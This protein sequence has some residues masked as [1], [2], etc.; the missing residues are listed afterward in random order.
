MLRSVLAFALVV[1]TLL[2]TPATV[3]AASPQAWI[4]LSDVHFDPFTQ[5][6]LVDRLAAA[7]PERWRAIFATGDV[8]APSG[9]GSDTN[10]ALLESTLDGAR[11]A[12]PDPRIV[13]VA[14]DF[15]A[16]DFR[17]KFERTAKVHDAAAY[18]AF[19]DKT[20][21]FLA[22]ELQAAFPRAHLLPVIG[23]NDNA[24]GDYQSTLHDAFLS[25]MAA[26][27]AGSAGAADPN[28]F[29]AQFSTGGYYTIPLPAGGA[30]AIVL[31]DVLWSV[32]YKNACG[33]PKTD[34]GGDELRWLQS[35]QAAIA[36]GTPV[37]VIAHMPPGVDVYATLHAPAG[38]APIPFLTDRF[39]DALLTAL[40]SSSTVV[41]S[42]AGH[43]HM[44]SFRAIGPDPSK[45]RAPMLVVPAVSPLFG[46]A[47]SF[48]VLDV[49]G[50][51]AQVNDE[52]IFIL[53]KSKDDWL[54]HREYDFDSVYGPG[55]IDAADVSRVQQ[56]IFDDERVRYRFEE[57]YQ[58]GD[59]IAPITDT[60]WRSYWCANVA[61]TLTEYTACAMPQIERDLPPHPS[62]PPAA[63]P[64]P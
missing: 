13:I 36:P 49:D 8:T 56:A 42:I 2:V 64:T 11:N 60:T 52:Q 16:H 22:W 63:T 45:P 20:I 7:P 30:Q 6:R 26:A 24:C 62:P 9:R 12:L 57:Y 33:D 4:V 38:S 15:L 59:G 43:T 34:P 55:P 25:H 53:T 18:A 54:W 37:W 51:T 39:N 19:V 27:W 58:S 50:S 47:P 29:I 1:A 40:D 61:L 5:P 3:L 35:T 44:N 21:A 41:M 23:N 32:N 46:N 28:A 14:G 17:A 31:N 48:T 10:D